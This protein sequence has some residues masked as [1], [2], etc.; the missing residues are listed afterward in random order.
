MLKEE[1][2]L[3]HLNGNHFVLV[4]PTTEN[5]KFKSMPKSKKPEIIEII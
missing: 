2:W 3:Y 4:A 5:H 1:M